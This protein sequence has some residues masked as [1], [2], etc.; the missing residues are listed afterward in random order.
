MQVSWQKALSNAVTDPAVLLEKLELDPALLPA[1]Q[2]AAKLF[3]LRVPLNFLQK[4]EKGNLNDPLLRQI[5]PVEMELHPVPGYESDP[6]QEKQSNPLP[7]M[8]HKYH[9]RA[10]VMVSTAC[11]INCRFCFRREFPY[12]DNNPGSNGWDKILNYLKSE[13]SIKEV[14]LSGGDPLA[15]NDQHLKNLIDNLVEV[16]HIKTV[17]IHT[18][19]PL[20]IPERITQELLAW[21]TETRLR[22]VLVIHCNHPNEMDSKFVE[23]MNLLRARDVLLLNQAVLLKGVNDSV[24]TLYQLSEALFA[25]GILP[26]YLHL[27]DKV[28]GTAHFNVEESTARQLMAELTK[29]LPG[30]LV[31]KLV[32][33]EPGRPSKT[34]I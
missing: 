21:L 28:R 9:G 27:L 11:A 29:K 5:L 14:I 30:Y 34:V 6:L 19:M 2:H 7:G 1:A 22:P 23:S 13:P 17:R 12:A 33:E 4:I 10:L 20:V 8:L 16:Q 31:P 18:R 15:A 26:Y 3:P 32:K 25:A 24:E